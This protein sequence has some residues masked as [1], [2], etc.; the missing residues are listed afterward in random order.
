MKLYPLTPEEDSV[1]K[2]VL[3]LAAHRGI[4]NADLARATGLIPQTVGTRLHG[5]T[6]FGVTDIFC[7]ADALNVEPHVLLLEPDDAVRWA[8][9]HDPV[10]SNVRS[11]YSAVGSQRRKPTTSVSASS[12]IAA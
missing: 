2:T 12:R 1:R 7:F 9:D 4:S 11:I 8:Y 10:Q 5:K 6:A 3:A